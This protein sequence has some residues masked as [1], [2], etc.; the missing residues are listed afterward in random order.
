MR[1]LMNPL[2]FSVEELDQLFCNHVG[3]KGKGKSKKSPSFLFPKFHA[4]SSF[5]IWWIRYSS[6]RH[7][8]KRIFDASRCFA[9]L[10]AHEVALPSWHSANRFSYKHEICPQERSSEL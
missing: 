8:Q 10:F 2:D 5:C 1:H 7:S 9:A 3:C 4:I 6:S